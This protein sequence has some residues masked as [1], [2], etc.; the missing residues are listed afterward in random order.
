MSADERTTL[1]RASALQ[2]T[3][4]AM[5]GLGDVDAASLAAAL[6]RVA[7]EDVAA[8]LADFEPEQKL[9]IFKAIGSAENQGIVLE[10]T[11]QQ[12]RRELLVALTQAERSEI[13]GE[14]SVDDLVDHLEVLPEEEQERIIA[15]LKTEEAREVQELRRYDPDTAGGM[16][17]T[18]FLTIPAGAT[19]GE[20]LLA[21]QGNLN[22]EVIAYVY[23]TDEQ[24]ILQGVVS[25]RE[26]LRAKPNVPVTEYMTREL[27]LVSLETDREDVAGV[28][29][30]YNL[31]VIPVVDDAGRMRGI[32]T[33]D[34][35]MDAVQE[36]HSEDML[37][38]AGTTAIHPVYESVQLGAARRL[39]FLLLT[40]VGGLSVFVFKALFDESISPELI[41]MALAAIPLLCGLTGNVAVVT[42]TVIVRGMATGEIA[43]RR[44][45]RALGHELTVGFLLS[46]ALPL[47]L[48]G[49]LVLL[50]SYLLEGADEYRPRVIPLVCLALCASVV[51]G[52]LV[53]GLVP[54]IC[55]LSRVIDPAIA[56]GPFVTMS[57]DISASFIFLLLVYLV[58]GT[59]SG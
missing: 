20:A 32:V 59:G 14:M 8:V 11:D 40:M 28:V 16:M 22:L 53:G 18:E 42:S 23:V 47:I 24:E 9:L 26:V 49:V 30:K 55:R 56:S 12:S 3:L 17:T 34:D 39:P 13:L 37:R 54:V 46:L 1:E 15:T 35:V 45:W 6:E 44:L 7:P 51:W 10:E 29:D 31:A 25:I 57:C 4:F 41:A 43:G 21:I 52:S 48:W 2:E 19:S 50:G 38:M 5:F 36:E 27:V 58:L 33:F